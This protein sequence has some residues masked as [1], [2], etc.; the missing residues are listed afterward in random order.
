MLIAK[1]I[2]YR[3]IHYNYKLP[4]IIDDATCIKWVV[5]YV[6]NGSC[7]VTCVDIVNWSV[8]IK[9]PVLNKNST[10]DEILSAIRYERDYVSGLILRCKYQSKPIRVEVDLNEYIINVYVRKNSLIDENDLLVDF[11]LS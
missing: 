1:N 11:N 10:Y 7:N 3:D 5:D 8:S 9:K 4:T 2:N 6:L